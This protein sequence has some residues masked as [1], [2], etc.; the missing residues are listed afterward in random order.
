MLFILEKKNK[1]D[2]QDVN[3]ADIIARIDESVSAEIPDETQDKVLHELV[4]KHMI[5]S[6]C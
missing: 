1:F 5:H 2:E 6:P 3:E 4:M